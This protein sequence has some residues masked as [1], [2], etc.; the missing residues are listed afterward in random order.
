MNKELMEIQS[1]KVKEL[2]DSINRKDSE[3]EQIR[4]R[5]LKEIKSE[6]VILFDGFKEFIENMFEKITITPY[7][8]VKQNEAFN[9]EERDAEI[10]T[11]RKFLEEKNRLPPS[12]P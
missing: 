3:L 8:N 4:R 1:K 9:S 11:F 7:K 12:Y 10:T 6:Q 2:E 5:Q